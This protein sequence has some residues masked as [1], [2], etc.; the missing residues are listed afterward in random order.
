MTANDAIQK[1]GT[2]EDTSETMT[3]LPKPNAWIMRQLTNDQNEPTPL[4]NT[5]DEQIEVQ[6][7]RRRVL[8]ALVVWRC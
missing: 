3:I 7:L 6:R 2:V 1:I 5:D 4:G 8:Q